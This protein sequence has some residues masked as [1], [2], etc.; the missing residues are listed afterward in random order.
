M[1]LLFEEMYFKNKE[2]KLPWRTV[3]SNLRLQEVAAMAL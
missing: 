1:I 3:R 2:F